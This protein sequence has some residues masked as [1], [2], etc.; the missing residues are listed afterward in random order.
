[1][2]VVAT[3]DGWLAHVK[4]VNELIRRR[5]PHVLC[6]G[7]DR[8]L[9]VGFRYL[10]VREGLRGGDA[11][12]DTPRSCKPSMTARPAFFLRKDGHKYRFRDME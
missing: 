8:S 11:C 12:T 2:L 6:D 9:F 10:I 3:E 1:V 4:G 7:I 5:E